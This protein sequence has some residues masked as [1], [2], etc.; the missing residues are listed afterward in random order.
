MSMKCYVL[1]LLSNVHFTQVM[2]EYSALENFWKRHNKVREVAI[3]RLPQLSVGAPHG[4]ML[5]S[6]PDPPAWDVN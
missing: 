3:V 4:N 5:A 2:H 6:L 1:R